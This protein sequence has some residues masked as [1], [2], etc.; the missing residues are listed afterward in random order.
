M[1]PDD[2]R[3]ELALRGEVL[4]GDDFTAEE[5][6]EWFADER[7]GYFNLYSHLYCSVGNSADRGSP[8]YEYQQL[9]DQHCFKWLP[10][11]EL[12]D[13]LGIGSAD[14]AELKPIITRSRSVTVLEPSDGFSSA[15]IDGKTVNYVKPQA[16]GRMPFESAS[17]D[18]VVCFGVLH[19]IPNVSTVVNDMFRVLKPGGYGLLREPTISMGD[20][21]LPRVG[22]TKHE[23]GIPLA[24]FRRIV[25]G[26]GFRIERE[27]QCMFSL[28]SRLLPLTGG[29]SVWTSKF[30]V[31]L[32][33]ILC[34]LPVWPR[35]Y[36]AQ[37]IR[38]KIRPTAVSFVL[39]KPETA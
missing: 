31:A 5:I 38:H 17:F 32:D 6:A 8:T 23:R 3:T 30:I 13:V 1:D 22:L 19:H 9:A 35:H 18:V 21:R 20:W 4:Y 34:A 28:M 25:S 16:S 12:G 24:I 2:L 36:G 26:A 27:T 29:A 14:G 37:R 33:R 15:I 10:Q 11:R 7:E 39:K